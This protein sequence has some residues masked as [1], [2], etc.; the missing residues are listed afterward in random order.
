MLIEFVLWSVSLIRM[1]P[2]LFHHSWEE[3]RRTDYS[4]ISYVNYECR[5]CGATKDTEERH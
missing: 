3:R 2:C 5:R 1:V 4:D